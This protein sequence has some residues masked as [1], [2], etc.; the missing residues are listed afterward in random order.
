MPFTTLGGSF[1]RVMCR[2]LVSTFRQVRRRQELH[3]SLRSSM[4]SRRGSRAYR[5]SETIDAT[6]S[7]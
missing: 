5:T 7:S 2:V 6:A 4:A 1:G 3:E